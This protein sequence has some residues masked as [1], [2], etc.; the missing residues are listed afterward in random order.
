MLGLSTVTQ[1]PQGDVI[2]RNETSTRFLDSSSD[3]ITVAN[4]SDLQIDGEDFSVSFWVK[5]TEDASSTSNKDGIIGIKAGQ[6]RQGGFWFEYQDDAGDDQHIVMYTSTT[7][8]KTYVASTG[9][10]IAND[11]WYHVVATY[12]LSTTTA[13][14]YLNGSVTKTNTSMNEPTAYTGT[15]YLGSASSYVSA[16]VCELALWKGYALTSGDVTHLYD[17]GF[18]A[19]TPMIIRPDKITGYWKLNRE[20]STGAGAVKDR[21]LTGGRNGTAVNLSAAD[22]RTTGSPTGV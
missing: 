2:Y 16:D 4:H 3:R 8:N 17:G 13:V 12:D 5:L 21:S 1:K 20:D 6:F 15:V 14:L 22:F 19:K 10:A 9:D 11:T 18:G 7:G